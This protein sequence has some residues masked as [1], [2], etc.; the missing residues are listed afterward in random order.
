MRSMQECGVVQQLLCLLE[1]HRHPTRSSRDL[2]SPWWGFELEA[3]QELQ[4]LPEQEADL[5]L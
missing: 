1:A 3:S 2:H 5:L 4:E